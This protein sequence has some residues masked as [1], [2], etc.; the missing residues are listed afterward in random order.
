M[1]NRWDDGP[2]ELIA[3]AALA[4]SVY[5]ASVR[6]SLLAGFGAPGP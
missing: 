2:L 5:S 4:L 1:A 6:E 3:I